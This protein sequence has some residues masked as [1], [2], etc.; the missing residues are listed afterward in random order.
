MGKLELPPLDPNAAPQEAN[1]DRER[2]RDYLRRK[3]AE[4]HLHPAR[5]RL[6]RGELQRLERRAA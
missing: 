5:E 6:M 1:G 3:L 4:W 2:Q